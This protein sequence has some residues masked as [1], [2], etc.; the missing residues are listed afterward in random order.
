MFSFQN[1]KKN[2]IDLIIRIKVYKFYYY[3]DQLQLESFRN[4]SLMHIDNFLSK[5]IHL[6]KLKRTFLIFPFNLF[7]T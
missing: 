1:D 7:L 4:S 6:L 5:L 2:M 3:A